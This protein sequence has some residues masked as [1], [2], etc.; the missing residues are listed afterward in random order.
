[1]PSPSSLNFLTFAPAFSILSIIYLELAPKRYPQGCHPFVLLAIEA[2][3]TIFY[4]TGFIALAIFLAKLVYC[5]GSVCAVA[6]A[7]SILAA[8]EFTSWIASTILL[9]K[10]ISQKGLK[11]DRELQSGSDTP[12]SEV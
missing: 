4:F 1:M 6:R 8:A 2:T 9:A 7:T 11:G 5:T 12:M 3:N 10:K